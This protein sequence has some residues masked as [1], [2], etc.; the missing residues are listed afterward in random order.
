[1]DRTVTVWPETPKVKPASREQME[2]LLHLV[3][4]CV[5]S[6]ERTNAQLA[7]QNAIECLS[8]LRAK[9]QIRIDYE[10]GTHVIISGG[11]VME[12]P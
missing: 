11:E 5:P 7:I 3:S 4:V 6:R 12:L 10:L 2:A 8:L 9:E 1:M